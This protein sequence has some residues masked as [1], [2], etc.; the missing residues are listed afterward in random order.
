[1][2]KER[3]GEYVEDP[4]ITVN[5]MNFRVTVIGEVNNP[6]TYQITGD[7]VSIIE[8][9]A[10]AGDLSVYGKRTSVLLVRESGDE[11]TSVRLDFTSKDVIESPYFYLQ[12]NDMIYVDPIQQRARSISPFVNNLPLIT[13]LGSLATSIAMVLISIAR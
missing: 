10:M 11:R 12:Q 2:L 1:M 7:R 5:F 9:I 6:G 13:S 4:I 3:L 8:A